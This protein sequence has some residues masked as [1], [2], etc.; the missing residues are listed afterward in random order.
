MAKARAMATLAAGRRTGGTG[1]F[2]NAR[3][4]TDFM[5]VLPRACLCVLALDAQHMHRCFDDV[6]QHGHVLPQV[7][8]LEHHRQFGAHFCS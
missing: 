3:V 8:V 5:Q 2:L 7:E 6:L 4:Q 1:I